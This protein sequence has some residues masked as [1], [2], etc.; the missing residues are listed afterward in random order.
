MYK[1]ETT[2][3]F[4]RVDLPRTLKKLH[5]IY[6]VCNFSVNYPLRLIVS[7]LQLRHFFSGKQARYVERNNLSYTS[8]ELS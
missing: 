8:T 6:V 4:L 5:L 1:Q 3:L 2:L 7:F